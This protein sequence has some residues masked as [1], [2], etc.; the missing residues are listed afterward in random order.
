MVMYTIYDGLKLKNKDIKLLEE[1][2][3]LQLD[4]SKL[5]ENRVAVVS[6]TAYSPREKE[7][8]STPEITAFMTKVNSDTMALS[9]NLVQRGFT[10]GKCVY[11][12]QG[13]SALG[14]FKINDLMA[15]Y[16]TY[17]ADI[18]YFNTSQAYKFGIRQGVTLVLLTTC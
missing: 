14:V 12:R 8:D 15:D 13:N 18:F 11:A 5:K 16:W 6:V 10:P 7:T 3:Q 1:I 17:R 2:I 9:W 4:I